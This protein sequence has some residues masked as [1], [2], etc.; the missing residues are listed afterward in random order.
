MLKLYVVPTYTEGLTGRKVVLSEDWFIDDHD[1][2]GGAA[3][4]DGRQDSSEQDI[5]LTGPRGRVEHSH[6]SRLS[7]YCV[8]ELYYELY[9]AGAKVDAKATHLNLNLVLFGLLLYGNMA[10]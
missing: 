8:L 1:G 2:A 3:V 4:E 6:W 5:T 7:R 9:Y 10:W